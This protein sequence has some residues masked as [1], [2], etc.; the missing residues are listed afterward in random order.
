MR[1]SVLIRVVFVLMILIGGGVRFN[2]HGSHKS[3]DDL[4]NPVPRIAIVGDSW[5]MFLWWFRSFQRALKDLG[6]EEYCE[7]ANESVVGGGKTFQFVNVEQF[8]AAQQ[9]RNAIRKMLL[10]CPTIDIV[11][12]SLGGNDALYGTE[13][14]LPDDPLRSIRMQCP[15]HPDNMNEI[16]AEKIINQDM[17]NLID[18]I[19]EIRPDIRILL[20]SYDFGGETKRSECDLMTQQLGIMLVDIY[21]QRLA[22]TKGDRVHFISNYGLMQYVYGVYEY[23]VDSG[24]DPIPGTEQLVYPPGYVKPGFSPDD[25]PPIRLP[26]PDDLW[27]FP[28]TENGVEV[29]V[30][31]FPQYFTPLV[32]LLD[33]DMHLS[34]EGYY[35]MARRIVERVVGVWL[36]YPKVFGIHPVNSEKGEQY[37]FDVVFSKEVTGVDESDFEIVTAEIEMGTKLDISEARIVSIEPSEGFS[38]VYKVVVDLNPN[39]N[40]EKGNL[41]EVVHINVIDDDSIVDL[42]GTPLGGPNTLNWTENG[43]FTFYGPFA[44]ADLTKPAEDNFEQVQAYLNVLTK[45]YLPFINFAVSFEEDK[46]DINGNLYPLVQRLINGEDVDVETLYIKG[47][48]LLDS[49]EFAVLERCLKDPSI[50]LS[51]RG[52]ISHQIVKTAWNNNLSRMRFDLGGEITPEHDNMVL[53]I[54]AGIDSLFAAYMTFGELRTVGTISAASIALLTDDVAR[55]LPGL[56]FRQIDAKNYQLLTDYLGAK[57]RNGDGVL[58]PREFA[59]ADKDGY[60]NAEEYLYFESDGKG[61]Y[62]EAVLNPDIRPV[63]LNTTPSEGDSIRLYVPQLL[64]VYLTTYEWYK[65]GEKLIDNDRIKGSDKRTLDINSIKL[66]DSGAYV[67]YYCENDPNNY[68]VKTYGPIVISVQ[69]LTSEGEGASEGQLEG[70]PSEGEFIEGSG[71]GGVEGIIEGES[72][73][74][75]IPGEGEPIIRYHRM[76]TNKDFKVQLGELLR[77]IQFFNS[78]SYSCPV[79]EVITEDGYIPGNSGFTSC[80]PHDL[81]Y[82]PQDWVI[83]LDEILRAIQYF[84]SAYYYWCP[85]ENTEDGFCIVDYNNP[86]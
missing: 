25:Y 54:F 52:G 7:V 39:L 53:R 80:E 61:V 21:K 56:T 19:L 78:G 42:S 4:P 85:N 71:E 59:D 41:K 6:Y 16:L 82:V 72:I 48:G 40:P 20:T 22:D 30:P 14:V 5:G 70:N 29:S 8:P 13:Y 68:V 18:F 60:T 76:D 51:G 47:N 65:D 26:N 63:A 83:S 31:G 77:V 84:N 35:I 46:L 62:V 12:I 38:R 15:G 81:D 50:D 1:S 44:F 28:W 64:H 86:D 11:V 3:L 66:E 57:D 49:Y 23:Q 27:T 74:G 17:S 37:I 33:Q 34:E 45:P 24:N 75:E 9:I 67:C 58:S 43:K 73:D 10:D 69:P 36:D 2:A 79:T 32:A 55:F